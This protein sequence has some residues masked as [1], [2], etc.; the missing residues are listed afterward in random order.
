M[1]DHDEDPETVAAFD[2]LR[3]LLERARAEGLD[4]TRL[5]SAAI[6]AACSLYRHI[7]GPGASPFAAATMRALA[8][9]EAARIAGLDMRLIGPARGTA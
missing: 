6:N 2:A 9:T 3:A 4:E 7:H 8:E 1:R 5:A